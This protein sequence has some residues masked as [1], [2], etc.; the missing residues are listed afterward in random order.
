[1]ISH[2]HR[3]IFIHVPKCA[4][5]A[6]EYALT[7]YTECV[8]H[9]GKGNGVQ[10]RNPDNWWGLLHPSWP[11]EMKHMTYSL[12]VHR[13]MKDGYPVHEYKVIS[14]IRNPWD[15]IVSQAHSMMKSDFRASALKVH[16][17]ARK[18]VM[19]VRHWWHNG[20]PR[21]PN[22]FDNLDIIIRYEHLHD[23]WDNFRASMPFDP[24]PLEVKNA[25]P[26]RKPHYSAYFRNRKDR[27][28]VRERFA[29]EIEYF[30]YTF[31]Q[32]PR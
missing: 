2:S 20:D 13:L 14:S 21:Q 23:D 28:Q 18:Q 1:M 32:E 9:Y 11:G 27:A 8:R 26:G 16:G 31:E 10:C 29:E 6:I 17:L 5:N 25:F 15:R 22:L 4:G 19:P 12:A 24:G 30:G 7:P 3:F